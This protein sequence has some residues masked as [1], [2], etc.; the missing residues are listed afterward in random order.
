VAASPAAPPAWPDPCVER[1]V[2]AAEAALWDGRG[3]PGREWL[4][5][6]G[7]SEQVLRANRVGFDP[8]RRALPRERGLPWRAAGVVYP[9]L[10]GE[11]AALYCQTRYLDPSAAGG[12]KYA[13]P[14]SELAANPRVAALRTTAPN[15]AADVTVVTEGIPDGLAAAHL[16]V[17]V[18]AVIGA[19]NHGTLVAHR[20]HQLFPGGTFLV[21]FDADHAGRRGG[22]L[23][24]AHLAALDREVVCTAPPCAHI[25]LNDWWRADR[26]AVLEAVVA[27][28]QALRRVT[29]PLEA[30][31]QALPR[32]PAAGPEVDLGMSR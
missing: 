11:G 17:R 27:A 9:V 20:L 1:Y 22:E 3:G 26:R 31:R 14:T 24:A 15:P 18:G 7:F 4:F 6:R 25:D 12:G 23:L 21:V 32:P 28:P 16:G 19:A 10:D 8:G 29:A 13:N 30:D 5:S 2:A